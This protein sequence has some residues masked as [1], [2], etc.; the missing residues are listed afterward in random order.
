MMHSEIENYP[1]WKGNRLRIPFF[2]L[3]LFSLLRLSLAL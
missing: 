3:A 1:I 2:D